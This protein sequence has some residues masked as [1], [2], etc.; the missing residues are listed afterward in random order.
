MLDPDLLRAFVAICET[1]SMTSAAE[2]VGRTPSAISL[3]MKKLEEFFGRGLLA[4]GSDGLVPTPAGEQLLSHA[5]RILRAEEEALAAMGRAPDGAHLVLG[6]SGDYGQV[7][8]PRALAAL[9]AWR[10]DITAEIVC[11][12]SSDLMTQVIEGRTDI[13]FVG[14]L[15]SISHGP[16]VHRERLVWASDGKCHEEDPMPL[17][18]VPRESLYRRWATERLESIGRRYRIN[19]TS[20]SIAGIQALVRSG[21]GVTVM[22]ESAL[23]P[24][25]VAVQGLPDLPPVEVRI[26]RCR[27][28][29]SASLRELE[30][31][32]N[33]RLRLE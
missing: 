29:D 23:V 33:E 18:L 5:R 17:A 6:I 26:E 2:I 32:L 27:A 14:E 9:R 8:L 15:E 1:G 30:I 22:S 3:Q 7:L 12:P 10:P 16:V 19:F 4:R 20:Y 13:A 11:A 21:G 31:F 25:I 24:G 28:R